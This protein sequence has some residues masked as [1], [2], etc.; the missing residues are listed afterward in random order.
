MITEFLITIL[1][2]V[3]V[4]IVNIFAVLPDV[5]LPAALNSSLAAISPYYAGLDTVFPI[6]TLIDI[7]GVE[8]GIIGAYLTYKLVRWAYVKIPTIN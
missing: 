4:F 6:G 3:V 7:L 2:N 1:Y 5:S 8:L